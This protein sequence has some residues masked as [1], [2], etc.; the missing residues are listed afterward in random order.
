M[1]FVVF[2]YIS[3][4][5]SFSTVLSFIDEDKKQRMASHNA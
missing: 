2:M 1:S 4:V 5:R 3:P